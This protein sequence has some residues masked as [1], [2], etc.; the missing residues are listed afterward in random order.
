[1]IVNNNDIIVKLFE[2]LYSLKK[3]T[4]KFVAIKKNI[5][6]KKIVLFK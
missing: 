6:K 1:M 4:I 2:S 3:Y 5:W